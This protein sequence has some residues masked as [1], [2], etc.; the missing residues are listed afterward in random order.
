MIVS[1][2]SV[3]G[4]IINISGN[5]QFNILTTNN[6]I[7]Y[8]FNNIIAVDGGRNNEL[9]LLTGPIILSYA[10]QT[11]V[12]NDN[13]VLIQ[14]TGQTFS[15]TFNKAISTPN[16]TITI[17]GSATGIWNSTIGSVL[18]YTFTNITLSST[19]V[20]FGTVTSSDGTISSGLIIVLNPVP[21]L[22]FDFI[23]DNISTPIS[24][25]IF[26]VTTQYTLYAKFKS[27]PNL[28]TSLIGIGI[29]CSN[30]TISSTPISIDSNSCLLYTSPSPRDRQKSRM[31]SSA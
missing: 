13:K 15:F 22:L 12:T 6:P 14:I 26:Y 20:T 27:P 9:T 18:T 17:N 8:T 2:G 25:T 10:N 4:K 31:P 30:A 11:D 5:L 28:N 23:T 19:T 16:P 21:A 24:N 3:T 7:T 1:E 29:S